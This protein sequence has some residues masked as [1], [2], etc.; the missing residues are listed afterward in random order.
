MSRVTEM[1]V[2][3]YRSRIFNGLPKV[4]ILK[5]RANKMLHNRALLV[6]EEAALIAEVPLDDPLTVRIVF[7]DLMEHLL[8]IQHW[9]PALHLD[10]V[11]AV[12]ER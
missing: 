1:K 7:H 3:A 12:Q 9:R 2:T 4:L 6:V 8:V 11:L 10:V 5:V